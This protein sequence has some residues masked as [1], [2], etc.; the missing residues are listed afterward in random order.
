MENAVLRSSSPPFVPDLKT[1]DQ[2]SITATWLGHATVLIQFYGITVLTDPVLFPRI[3]ARTS[4]GT[5]GPKRLVG[6]ALRPS[7]LPEVDLVVLSH[8]HLDHLDKPS[9][10]SLRGT[11]QIVTAANTEDLLRGTRTSGVHPLRW[12]D[13]REIQTRKGAVQVRA[14]EVAHWG[15]RW[16]YDRYRGYNGYVLGREGKQIIFGGD[17]ALSPSFRELRAKGPFCAAFMPIGAYDPWICSHCTPEQAVDMAN[18]AKASHFLPI[19]FKTFAFGREGIQAPLQRL[20]QVLEVERLG[21]REIGQTF[22]LS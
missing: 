14:F 15:A 19:H 2:N 7:Q 21:W 6:P 20:D 13:H 22:R 1:W 12:G 17:T 8:A 10:R 16:R 3:G 5:V 11:P 4:F 9:L 18:D